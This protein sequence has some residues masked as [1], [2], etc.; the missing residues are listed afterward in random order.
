MTTLKPGDR[1]T[2]VAVVESEG[3]DDQHVIV[4]IGGTPVQV[5]A[6]SSSP[7]RTPPVHYRWPAVCGGDSPDDPWDE[8]LDRVDCGARLTAT[9]KKET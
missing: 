2:I 1:V 7:P 4:R 9:A 5:P 8:D 6:S 3:H